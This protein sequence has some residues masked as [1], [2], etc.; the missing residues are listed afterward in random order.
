MREPWQEGDYHLCRPSEK[1]GGKP[2]MQSELPDINQQDEANNPLIYTAIC[3]KLSDDGHCQPAPSWPRG[4][5]A[6]S[7]QCRLLAKLS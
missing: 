4:C 7:K 3:L 1:L 6:T 5:R 2:E